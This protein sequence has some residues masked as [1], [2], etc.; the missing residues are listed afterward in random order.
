MEFLFIFSDDVMVILFRSHENMGKYSEESIEKCMYF[1]FKQS[2]G[3]RYHLVSTNHLKWKL[4]MRRISI[5]R[6]AI[7]SHVDLHHID[8]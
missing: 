8:G 6:F 2:N 1:V 3:I 5:A 7:R 4:S